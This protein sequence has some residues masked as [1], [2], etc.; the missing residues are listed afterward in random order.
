MFLFWFVTLHVCNLR[1]R[2]ISL[3]QTFLSRY[4]AYR[5][6]ITYLLARG[7]KARCQDVCLLFQAKAQSGLGQKPRNNQCPCHPGVDSFASCIMVYHFHMIVISSF[8]LDTAFESFDVIYAKDVCRIIAHQQRY[9][10]PCLFGYGTKGY[11]GMLL[12]MTTDSYIVVKAL[13]KDLPPS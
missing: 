9:W 1:S 13:S 2:N 10:N 12:F 11:L 8:K 7:P 6:R 3:L 5:I 4:N